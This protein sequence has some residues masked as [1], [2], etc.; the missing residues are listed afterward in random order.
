M[1]SE[2]CIGPRRQHAADADIFRGEA[3]L[4]A[5][6]QCAGNIDYRICQRRRDAGVN[7]SQAGTAK[8]RLGLQLRLR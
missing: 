2:P 7:G 6:Y 5:E 4:N 1:N 8:D 3:R